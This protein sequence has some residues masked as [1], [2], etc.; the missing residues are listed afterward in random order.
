MKLSVSTGR[1]GHRLTDLME[2]QMEKL[3]KFIKHS[4]GKGDV[5]RKISFIYVALIWLL[6][7]Y[8]LYGFL[9]NALCTLAVY[10]ANVLADR[11]WI[12]KGVMEKL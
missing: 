5:A 3:W 11:L 7:P 8:T 9:M 10:G 2:N 6:G 12:Y 4:W 1:T